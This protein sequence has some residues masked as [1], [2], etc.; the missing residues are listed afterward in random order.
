MKKDYYIIKNAISKEL[1]EF[2]A[3]EFDMMET[4]CRHLY[5]N[6]NLADLSENTFARYSPLMMEA[7]SVFLQPKI[8]KTVGIKLFPTYS[9]A[10]TYYKNS[11]LKKH[12]DRASSEVTV[13]VCLQQNS[14]WPLY[15]K[16]TEGHIHAINLEV[17]D[18]G[19][20]CGRAHEHWRE[21]LHEEKQI[22]AFLQYVNAEGDDAWLKWDTRPCLGLPFEY[23]T[24]HVKSEISHIK[25]MHDL[26]NSVKKN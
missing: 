7:L 12:I 8:E 17:G 16:N 11:Q 25:M 1:A 5:P 24:D 15:L 2:I 13:S 20:Y 23:A 21:P 3:L 9:Y 4:T 26:V 14:N 18:A 10:R 22:Q 6:A 19:I